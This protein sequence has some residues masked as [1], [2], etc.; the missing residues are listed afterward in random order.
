[1]QTVIDQAGFSGKPHPQ[2][3]AELARFIALLV[4]AGV[5]SYLEVGCRYGDTVHAVGR[6]LARGS[7]IVALDLPG[8]KSGQ[9]NKGGHQDSGRYLEAAVA[10]LRGA[11]GHDAR[12]IFGDS[13]HPATLAQ[14]AALGPYDALLIDGDHTAVGVMQDWLDY[15]PLARIV[16]FHDIAG[17][18]K[19]SRQ[20]RPVFEAAAI[21][22]HHRTFIQDGKRRG[23][24]VVWRDGAPP[25]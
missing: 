16:A 12:V 13:H 8:A 23:I 20:V 1:M 6:A 11:C 17:E 15:G 3:P 24:G 7:R 18:G 10:D 4:A 22:R 25:A 21:G 19:W 14:A 5:R 9:I 2:Y